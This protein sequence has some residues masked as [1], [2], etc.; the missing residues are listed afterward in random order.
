MVNGNY[1]PIQPYIHGYTVNTN[2]IIA[3]TAEHC[4]NLWSIIVNAVVT[5]RGAFIVIREL[6]EKGNTANVCNAL[7][8][9]LPDKTARLMQPMTYG[10]TLCC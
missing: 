2:N 4:I 10:L 3:F 1:P 5:M 8:A 7:M 9:D 6:I